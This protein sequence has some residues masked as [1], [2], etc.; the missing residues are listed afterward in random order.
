M[1]A[2]KIKKGDMVEL[3][4]GKDKGRQGKVIAVN[5]KKNTVIVENANKMKKAMRR[6]ANGE[7]GI[8]ETEAPLHISNVMLLVDG[9]K[10]RVGFRFDENNKKVRYAKKT[11]KTIID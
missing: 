5:A 6:N 11:G 7:G 4:A 9:T 1:S 10:T 3:I 2:L 8:V